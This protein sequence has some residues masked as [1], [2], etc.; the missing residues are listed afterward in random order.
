M[1]AVATPT[2]DPPL[3]ESPG[4]A[5]VKNNTTATTS[6]LKVREDCIAFRRLL[7]RVKMRIYFKIINENCSVFDN[8]EIF[9]HCFRP[10]SFPNYAPKLNV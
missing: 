4:I 10:F 1:L 7:L 9:E 8:K 5:V 3:V 6:S 2:G